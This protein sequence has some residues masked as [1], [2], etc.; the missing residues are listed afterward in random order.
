MD[1][2]IRKELLTIYNGTN[3]KFNQSCSKTSQKWSLYADYLINTLDN[4]EP[5]K[6]AIIVAGHV[7]NENNINTTNAEVQIKEIMNQNNNTKS[8]S[9]Y[10]IRHGNA[11]HNNPFS[12]KGDKQLTLDSMLTP[13]GMFQATELG[14]QIKKDIDIIVNKSNSKLKIYLWCSFLM[15][16]QMT[17]LCV[18]KQLTNSFALSYNVSNMKKCY[19]IYLQLL[20]QRMIILIDGV[21]HSK[22][23]AIKKN[24]YEN[25]LEITNIID[26]LSNKNTNK[27]KNQEQ[28]ADNSIA[29]NSIANPFFINHIFNKDIYPTILRKYYYLTKLHGQEIESKNNNNQ[30]GEIENKK[31]IES[32]EFNFFKELLLPKKDEHTNQYLE[33]LKKK[34]INPDIFTKRLNTIQIND[35]SMLDICAIKDK[36]YEDYYRCLEDPQSVNKNIIPTPGSKNYLNDNFSGGNPKKNRRNTKKQSNK[37]NK[38]HKNTIKHI[39]KN[40]KRI[41]SNKL[42]HNKHKTTNKYKQ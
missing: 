5:H 16:T 35:V 40:S 19:Y 7:G 3:N 2:D 34:Y 41:K 29:D 42:R 13:Y 22:H 32:K 33:Y 36:T 21:H 30:K 20:M 28:I 14:E 39:K 10:I 38:Q 17:G 4:N 27:D 11:F 24:I 18:I 31:E 15:R 1:N 37:K 26:E 9:I 6:V 12:I 25:T 8:L 23:S